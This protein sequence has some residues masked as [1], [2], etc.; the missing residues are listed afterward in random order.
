MMGWIRETV[1]VLVPLASLVVLTAS[2]DRNVAPFDP[3]EEPSE[4]NLG[5]IFPEG[6][7]RAAAPTDSMAMA[8]QAPPDLGVARGT[9]PAAPG[10]AG[11]PISG[12]IDLAD[13]LSAPAGSVLFIIA[14][15]GDA[16][17]P[18]A[19]KRVMGA[20]FPLEFELGPDDRM[21]QAMPFEG[22]FN[23]SARIDGDGNAMSRNP[24]DLQGALAAPV[25]PGDR[26]LDLLI[27]QKL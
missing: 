16:G 23:V 9:L 24:G 13:G 21:I 11:D 10:P 20:S 1:V 4:P 27:D 19:V 18:L 3:E 14:R 22:P 25:G 7:K 17:P 8:K 26:G 6:A 15:R 5:K 12:T 2:C